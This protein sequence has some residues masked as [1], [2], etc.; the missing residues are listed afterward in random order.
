MRRTA[1]IALRA[2]PAL[3]LLRFCVIV[4]RS[5]AQI[6]S[7]L[8]LGYHH[9]LSWLLEQYVL[10]LFSGVFFL[11]FYFSKARGPFFLAKFNDLC[12]SII[13]S[14]GKTSSY[15]ELR[16]MKGSAPLPDIKLYNKWID[17]LE[18]LKDGY[19]LAGVIPEMRLGGLIVASA[20]YSRVF[21]ILCNMGSFDKCAVLLNDMHRNGIPA[22]PS[23]SSTLAT[24]PASP[25]L[26]KCVDILDNM[27]QNIKSSSTQK[28]PA[29][30]ESA[31][32]LQQLR[33]GLY[34]NMSSTTVLYNGVMAQA[35]SL[36]V[37]LEV[38]EEMKKNGI[39]PDTFTLNTLMD[40]AAK[41]SLAKCV[42]IINLFKPLGVFPDIVTYNAIIQSRVQKN[43]K[44][45]CLAFL[46]I[47]KEKGVQPSVVTYSELLHLARK[48]RDRLFFID[49]V[50]ML[51][52]SGETLTPSLRNLLETPGDKYY[53][54]N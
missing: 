5:L 36:P 39:T 51:K 8:V 13:Q 23:F 41:E 52:E 7:F 16:K 19:G 50:K 12:S 32:L 22:P 24:K 28:K 44:K 30:Q 2:S 26:Q 15:A 31:L 43:D 35:S 27:K 37:A 17:V 34:A 3:R 40:K 38:Y 6:K 21:N 1:C 18:V 20:T 25:E 10:L 33:T 42:E 14:R 4:L 9:V 29:T 11:F 53:W 48:T 54:N 46:E 49:I 45:G 47:M